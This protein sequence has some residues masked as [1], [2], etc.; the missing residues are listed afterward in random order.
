MLGQ[1]YVSYRVGYV[2]APFLALFETM[3]QT[4]CP[5]PEWERDIPNPAARR[6]RKEPEGRMRWITQAEA[7]SL[8]WA[9]EPESWI[10]TSTTRD[11]PAPSGW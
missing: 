6:K 7:R 4:A 10:T 9:A 8:I 11:T 5:H 1:R 2:D 3:A